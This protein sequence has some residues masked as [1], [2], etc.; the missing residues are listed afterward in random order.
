MAKMQRVKGAA[1]EREVAKFFSEVLDLDFKRVLG[2]ERDGGG[3]VQAE[4]SDLLI[5]CK[6]YKAMKGLY[7][8]MRQA[9][10]SSFGTLVPRIPVLAIRTDGEESLLVI[11]M[12]DTV[13][14]AK[15][16]LPDA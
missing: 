5:E 9:A 3:D 7:G 11:R 10:I 12:K 6:R 14:F 13:P 1:Y 16:I 8:W 15:E 2:Q 4:G